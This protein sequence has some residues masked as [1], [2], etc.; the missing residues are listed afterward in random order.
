MVGLRHRHERGQVLGHGEA[1]Q[2]L[3]LAVELAGRE[4]EQAQDVVTD[5]DPAS[6]HGQGEGP[7]SQVLALDGH[8]RG[9]A[10]DG[11]RDQ[12]EARAVLGFEALR[13]LGQGEEAAATVAAHRQ[14]GEG[15]AAVRAGN[16]AVGGD[17]DLVG[18][19]VDR[20]RGARDGRLGLQGPRAGPQL[21][22]AVVDL[23]DVGADLLRLHDDLVVF[24]GHYVADELL[25]VGVVVGAGEGVAEQAGEL[26]GEIRRV[27]GLEGPPRRRRVAGGLAVLGGVGV[28]QQ[29][30]GRAERHRATRRDRDPRFG[31][32]L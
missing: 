13:A 10:G 30:G 20:P 32:R 11:V 17:Q 16:R 2:R 3:D 8:G 12:L 29:D 24:A 25:L 26:R 15:E 31:I 18:T 14:G 6:V 7:R 23:A 5:L 28:G 19:R 21:A 4:A 27:R 1:E 22:H 9:G